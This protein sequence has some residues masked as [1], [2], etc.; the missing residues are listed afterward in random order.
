MNL[1]NKKNRLN[2]IPFNF[3]LLDTA[4]AGERQDEALALGA[5]HQSFYK[6]DKEENRRA[7]PYLFELQAGTHFSNWYFQNGWGQAWGVP[8]FASGNFEEVYHHFRKFLM[9]KTEAG[10]RLY[11]RFYDPRV[12]R[13]F[14]PT[15][16]ASQIIEFFGPVKIF[17]CE[18][19]DPGSLLVF[20]HYQGKLKVDKFENTLRQLASN[21]NI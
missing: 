5:Q 19:E 11:F 9:I 21:S 7:S 15:C 4:T 16:D 12:L 6:G 17:I 10:E 13:T 2:L 8:V 18:D 3:L 20:S 14:L 1:I